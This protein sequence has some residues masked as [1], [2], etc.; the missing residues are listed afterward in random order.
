M[1]N[2]P[3]LFEEEADL[4]TAYAEAVTVKI[5]FGVPYDQPDMP[6]TGT[7]EEAK[8]L[9]L[10]EAK[11]MVEIMRTKAVKDAFEKGKIKEV[12]A[13]IAYLNHLK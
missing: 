10:E 6:K 2:F 8:V 13:L 1:P 5:M 7:L 4:D 3:W 9:A 11:P 12:V